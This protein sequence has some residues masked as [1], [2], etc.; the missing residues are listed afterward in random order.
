MHVVVG[1]AVLREALAGGADAREQ[2]ACAVGRGA[3]VRARRQAR[4]HAL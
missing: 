1:A 3:R 2:G 4:A